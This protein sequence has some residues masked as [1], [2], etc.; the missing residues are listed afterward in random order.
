MPTVTVHVEASLHPLLAP[1]ARGRPV[2]VSTAPTDT[3]GHVVESIGVPLTEVGDPVLD[4]LRVTWAE[5]AATGNLHV[6]PVSR[7]QPTPTEPPRFLLDVHL[8]RLARYMRLLG[9]DTA[10]SSDADDAE[11]AR[12]SGDERRVLLTRDRRLLHRRALAAGALVRSGQLA[13]QLTDVLDRFAPPLHPWTRCMACGGTLG[14]A[15]RDEVADELA[16]GTARTYDTFSRC[17]SCRRVYWRGAHAARLEPVVDSARLTVERRVRV[18]GGG[19]A[20]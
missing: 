20:G 8:G 2:V 14:P 9:V 5:R 12:R 1:T 7:P 16:A 10:W 15:R 13:E 3:L 6:T 17:T 19:A 4:G 11:L 18:A